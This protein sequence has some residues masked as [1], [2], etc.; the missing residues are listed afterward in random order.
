MIELVHLKK[1]YEK[2]TPFKDIN[3]TI[4]DGDI[5]SII[6]PSGTGKS[7][8]IRCINMLEKPTSGHIYIDGEDV[9]N[10][11]CDIIK[12][13]KKIG[14]VFQSFNLF[15]NL[16]VIENVMRPAVDLLGMS[17]QLAY[18]KAMDL[19]EMVDMDDR[20]MD[21]PYMLSGGQK[22]RVAIA[23]TLSM[24]PEIIML[25]EPTSALDPTMISEVENVIKKLTSL[26]KTMIVVTHEMRF[27]RE[28]SS[29]VFFMA[30]GGIYMDGTPEE[31][32]D[33]PKD[34]KLRKFLHLNS[35]LQINIDNEHKDFVSNINDIM[36]FGIKEHLPSNMIV[37][38]QSAFEE[39]CH[40]II[41]PTLDNP[42]LLFTVEYHQHELKAYVNVY[43]NGEA[44]NPNTSDNEL[45]LKLLENVVDEMNYVSNIQEDYTN[46]IALTFINR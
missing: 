1:E 39:L 32:F 27:A 46:R 3:V 14:M 23:R 16:T 33:N 40:Q 18:D 30:E 4:N 44:F 19:L 28:I 20:T 35:K 12:I 11:S 13:R 5:V 17:K 24:D 43:Y 36:E 29:R 34:E 8:L 25:D 9:T 26:G 10:P 41:L 45:S 22:Q 21:Y 2:I 42:K 15:D 31:V 7:T 38:I 6:G 37:R